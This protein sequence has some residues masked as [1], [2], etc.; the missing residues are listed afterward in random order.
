MNVYIYVEGRDRLNIANYNLPIDGESL[1]RVK[2]LLEQQK[3]FKNAQQKYG[4]EP[5]KKSVI[6]SEN[7]DN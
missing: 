6:S 5:S 1:A 7:Q 4:W 2:Q 3:I